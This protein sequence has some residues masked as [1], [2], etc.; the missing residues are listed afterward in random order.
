MYDEKAGENAEGSLWALIQVNIS[1]K[2]VYSEYDL[3]SMSVGHL[4]RGRVLCL[5]NDFQS[6]NE[7]E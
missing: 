1:I 6:L 3:F 5:G 7:P 4:S 2:L